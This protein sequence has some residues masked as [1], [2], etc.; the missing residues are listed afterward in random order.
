MQQQISHL[1]V[2]IFNYLPSINNKSHFKCQF[3]IV[4][5]I[6]PLIQIISAYSFDL[7]TTT[8]VFIAE[9]HHCHTLPNLPLQVGKSTVVSLCRQARQN[10]ARN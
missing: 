1:Q 8:V 3:G 10:R 2:V 9:N 5:I 6:S 4:L 7:R